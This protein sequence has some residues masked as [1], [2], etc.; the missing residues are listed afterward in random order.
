MSTAFLTCPLCEATCGLELT[1]RAEE[2][3]VRGDREDV[4]SRGYVC[5]K[6]TSIGALHS[7]PDRLRRP[8]IKRDGVHVEVSWDEAFAEIEARLL[9][10]VREQGADAVGVYFGNPTAHTLAGA[11]YLRALLKAVGTK[12]VFSAGSVDQIP[13]V[14]SSAYLYGDP[15]TIPVPDLDRTDHLLVLG[16]NPLVSNGSLM[17][18]PDMRGRIAAIRE[19]G[20]VV[21]VDPARTR[22]AEAATEHIAIR[23]GTD[24]LL[25][26]G[27]LHTIFAERLDDLR[28]AAPHVTGVD[29]VRRIAADYAPEIVA[30]HTGI[31]AETIKRLARELAA[32]E[33]AAV[34]GRMGTTTQEFGT[35][36]SWLVDVLNTV[37][38]NLDRPGGIMFP[39]AAA[40]QPNSRPGRRKPFR[41][42]RWTSRVTGL[43]EI[44]GE[45]P[46]ATLAD[47]ID[48]PGAG[49]VR[50]LIT[51]YG[52][53]CVSAPNAGRVDAALAGLDFMVSLDVYLNETTRHADVV[54]PGPTPLERGHYD[55]LLY[56]Y[57]V[58]NIARWSEPVFE[59]P[60]PQE[61]VTMVRLT[62]VLL[63]LGPDADVAALDAA[64]AAQ[65]AQLS[66]KSPA[67]GLTGPERL[68]DILLQAGP[69][70]LT[71]AE[72]RAAEHGIDL[73]PLRPRLPGVLATASGKVDLAPA[74]ITADLPRLAA[75]LAGPPAAGMVLIGRRHL[76]SNNSWMHNLAALNG[77]SNTCTVH[78]H[79]D[80]AHRLGLSTGDRA[81]LT[82][83][84]GKVLAPVEVTD[85]I[86]P[87][88]VSLPHGW[89]HDLPD[90]RTAIA[91]ARPGVNSNLLGDDE[92]LDVPTGT[93]AVNGIPVRV[94][95]A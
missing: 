58:R 36:T 28:D 8:L 6:G 35:L 21:V 44:M 42:G 68:L 24:A 4:F 52:N 80:D 14:F 46:V 18:A 57:A 76:R 61:W 3:R 2:I 29:E 89:G 95:P 27:M 31:D 72:V 75:M 82:T 71:F 84:T 85:G 65:V 62:G 47:E 81:E 92:R 40:G 7:D 38:G 20:T 30:A 34:Y 5:P 93:A 91:T 70:G 56:Q 54:L 26:L 1:I 49:Q 77:G 45:F 39:L 10:I 12:N 90:T 19:R 41:H 86:R 51:M 64:M 78:I 15:A 37:T 79:P 13:K 74:A 66:G 55:L 50:A 9:P 32:A 83:R 60:V 22:T 25:L 63:G 53:P 33:R 23:P 67:E 94:A 16:G 88:V 11:L 69:Y 59:T 48:T 43:P 17:T 87:G 73:G